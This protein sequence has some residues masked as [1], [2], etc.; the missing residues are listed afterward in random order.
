MRVCL[1]TDTLGDV[2]GVSRFIRNVAEQAEGA[3]RDLRVVTSTQFEVPAR[4]NIVKFRPI[5]AGKMPK[6]ENLE[7]VIPPAR[8]M[9]RYVRAARPDAI[10]ISTP[11]PVGSVGWWAARRLGIPVLGVYHTD[12][13]AYIDYL[14]GDDAMTWGCARWMSFFYGPFERVFTRSADYRGSLVRLG[15]ED[16]RIVRLLP[17]IDTSLFDPRFRDEGIW[18]RLGVPPGVKVIYCGRVSVE[19]NLPDLRKLWP[20]ARRLCGEVAAQLVVVGDGPYRETMQREL[21]GTDAYFLGF[22]HGRELSTIYASSDLF[23]FPST[24]DTLGQVVMESQCSG[25]PVIVT[26]QGGPK[27]VVRS[28][29]T[30]LVL[31]SGDTRRW[32][33]EIAGLVNDESKR[34][35][36]G[37]AAREAISPMSI[38]H[39]FEHFWKVHEDAVEERANRG[40]GRA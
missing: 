10:H 4:K 19:K 3:G 18:D 8:K 7:F 27:E 25:L 29:V 34:K 11:G 39:S 24:T 13:P 16:S 35:A 20:E 21:A 30:G 33:A 6:Y 17:G 14:F 9:L 2:N 38:R 32:A 5:V 31:P 15:I 40:R 22:K 12:F 26:D 36:W 1:F 28:G 37:S 23:V